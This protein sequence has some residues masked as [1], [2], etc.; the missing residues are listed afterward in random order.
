M[1]KGCARKATCAKLTLRASAAVGDG[2]TD[3]PGT[4]AD[5]HASNSRMEEDT[6]NDRPEID[7]ETGSHY[8][9]DEGD[10]EEEDNMPSFE[11]RFETAKLLIELEDNT[12]AAIQ[13]RNSLQL[14]F[15]KLWPCF[16]WC[17]GV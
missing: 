9:S 6:S 10:D 16:S 4:A 1:C 3:A 14:A 13:A 7:D 5:Q 17:S 11:F 8:D 2:S 12:D 15:A